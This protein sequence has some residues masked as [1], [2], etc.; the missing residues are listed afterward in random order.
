MVDFRIPLIPQDIA[1]LVV[2]EHDPLGQG[3]DGRAQAS[4][5]QCGGLLGLVEG[6]ARHGPGRGMNPAG[7]S[8]QSTRDCGPGPGKGG[9]WHYRLKIGHDVAHMSA[10]TRRQVW[11][12]H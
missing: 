10:K 4:L 7:K 11:S 3:V 9:F 1:S 8:A 2:E 6:F 5:G 12:R